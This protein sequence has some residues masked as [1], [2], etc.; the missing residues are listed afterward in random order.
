MSNKHEVY[1]SAAGIIV[2]ACIISVFSIFYAKNGKALL[3]M[4]AKLRNTIEIPL[5]QADSLKADYDSKNLEVY[6][7]QEDK[8]VIKEYLTSGSNDAK[9]TVDFDG[10]K[11]IVTGGKSEWSLGNLF[12][13]DGNQRI[14]IYLPASGINE[15][16]LATGSGNIRTKGK[17]AIEIQRADIHTGSGNITWE[18]TT[19]Q[20]IAFNANSGNIRIDN[21]K[22]DT[23]LHTGSGNI[24]VEE[25]RGSCM[26]EAGSGNIKVSAAEITGDVTLETGSGNQRLELPDKL[27]FS[28][29]V[30]TGSGNIHTDYDEVLSYNNKGDIAT[31][32]VG[33]NPICRINLQAGSGNV[34]LRKR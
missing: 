27:S 24:T 11:A 23:Q 15:L 6:V 25:L 26:A 20:D 4:S 5:S 16:E 18:N 28:L 14:E 31:A 17:F 8:I 33:D 34:T 13:G 22:G 9:A 32:K 10:N 12:W 3:P 29:E 30:H 19:A 1:A 21:I 2:V 7:W